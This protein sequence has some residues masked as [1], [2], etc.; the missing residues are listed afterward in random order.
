MNALE[1]TEWLL[2]QPPPRSRGLIVNMPAGG[3]TFHAR[4]FQA[5]MWREYAMTW[6]GRKTR[7]GI[8]QLWCEQI[9]RMTYAGCLRRARVNVYLARRA[10]RESNTLPRMS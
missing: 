4:L 10:R 6:H 9:G 2:R 3:M 7:N 8:D 5:R 1:V